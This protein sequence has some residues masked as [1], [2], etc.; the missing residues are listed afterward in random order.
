M[1]MAIHMDKIN[2]INGRDQPAPASTWCNLET[3][4]D[5]EDV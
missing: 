5:D 2:E 3:V 1:I 4:I